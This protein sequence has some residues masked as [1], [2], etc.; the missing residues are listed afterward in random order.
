MDTSPC[1]QVTGNFRSTVFI[2]KIADELFTGLK[3][4]A[5]RGAAGLSL[6]LI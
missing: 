3:Y 6:F 1:N 4:V 5:T 2:A